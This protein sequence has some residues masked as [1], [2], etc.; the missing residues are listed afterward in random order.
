MQA[1][2]ISIQRVC[3]CALLG[4]GPVA[5]LAQAAVVQASARDGGHLGR[6]VFCVFF[7]PEGYLVVRRTACVRRAVHTQWQ[8][9]VMARRSLHELLS[10]WEEHVVWRAI[11]GP[12]SLPLRLPRPS[13]EKALFDKDI[14]ISADGSFLQD[15]DKVYVLSVKPLRHRVLTID[16]FHGFSHALGGAAA[17][18][19]EDHRHNDRG[20]ISRNM[21]RIARRTGEGEWSQMKVGFV[22]Q[23]IIHI[24]RRFRARLQARM[25][26]RPLAVVGTDDSSASAQM[27]VRHDSSRTDQLLFVA[28]DTGC[29]KTTGVPKHVHQKH[30][31]RVACLLP[32][33]LQARSVAAYTQSTVDNKTEVGYAVGREEAS[34]LGL[35]LESDDSRDSSSVSV[36]DGDDV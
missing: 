12:A 32:R 1:G 10:I 36:S 6:C 5:I 16:Y 7:R 11:G 34:S 30:R 23:R 21:I 4:F 19:H 29:G 20:H 14:I 17:V 2:V 25:S 31:L 9:S 33:R 27:T 13:D 24:Q 28:G 35:D 18:F 8:A 15:G 22:V 3:A 26:Q